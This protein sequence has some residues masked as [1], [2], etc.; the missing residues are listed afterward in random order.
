MDN[1]I[2]A[3]VNVSN[4]SYEPFTFNYLEFGLDDTPDTDLTPGFE[5]TYNFINSHLL[6][7]RNVLVHCMA[8]MSRSVSYVIYYYIKKGWSFA[9]A[10][11]HIRMVR[12]I[13]APNPGFRKQLIKVALFSQ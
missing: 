10:I 11:A 6:E 4:R 9:E 3:I 7:G 12:P 1:N 5:P 2:E 13:A 8:G